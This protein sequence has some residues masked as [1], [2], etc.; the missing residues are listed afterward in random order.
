MEKK[1]ELIQIR[2]D[3]DLKEEFFRTAESRGDSPSSLLRSLMHQAVNEQEGRVGYLEEW[4]RSVNTILLELLSFIQRSEFVA[5]SNDT[6]HLYE[7]SFL[8]EYL[9]ELITYSLE[10]RKLQGKAYWTDY[11][12]EIDN[13]W[14]TKFSESPPI[15]SVHLRRDTMEELREQIQT[16]VADQET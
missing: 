14:F 5:G 10:D 8:P 4:R 7:T 1:Q 2:V 11:W 3:S 13:N 15:L 12:R 9:D 16:A 6:W